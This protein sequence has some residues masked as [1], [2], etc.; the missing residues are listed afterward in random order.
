MELRHSST[1]LLEVYSPKEQLFILPL[2]VTITVSDS[3]AGGDGAEG[4]HGDARAWEKCT[5][6]LYRPRTDFLT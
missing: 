2:H 5:L 4:A 6:S 3:A 1:P